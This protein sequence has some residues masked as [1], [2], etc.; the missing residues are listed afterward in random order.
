MIARQ[1]AWGRGIAIAFAGR[2]GRWWLVGRIRMSFVVVAWEWVVAAAAGG[3]AGIGGA[4]GAA[5]PAAA[6]A[7]VVAPEIR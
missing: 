7:G 1:V 6:T 5:N 3:V 4:I 2:I